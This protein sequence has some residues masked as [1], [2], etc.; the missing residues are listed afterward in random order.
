MYH[1]YTTA[2]PSRLPRQSLLAACS[3]TAPRYDG[4]TAALLHWHLRLHEHHL[5]GGNLLTVE[6]CALT[7]KAGSLTSKLL[8]FTCSI[9]LVLRCWRERGSSTGPVSM[10]VFFFTHFHGSFYSMSN[11]FRGAN[12]ASYRQSN[13]TLTKWKVCSLCTGTNRL[14]TDELIYSR[15]TRTHNCAGLF[16]CIY[17]NVSLKCR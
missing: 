10:W 15:F 16:G 6:M 5:T 13:S 9:L 14:W 7:V 1:Q 3:W 8:S 11:L 4:H 2:Y 17:N 12:I